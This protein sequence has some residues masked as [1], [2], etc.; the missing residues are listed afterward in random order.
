ML[1]RPGTTS[2]SPHLPAVTTRCAV[3]CCCATDHNYYTAVVRGM[4]Q[5]DWMF[6]CRTLALLMISGNV[7]HVGPVSR[8]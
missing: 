7:P 6:G 3:L 2:T 4:P 8:C 1:V 5:P